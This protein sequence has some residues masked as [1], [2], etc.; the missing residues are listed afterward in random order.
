MGKLRVLSAKQVCQI[1][2]EQGFIQVRQRGSHIIMQKKIDDST[3]T[4]PV[5]NYSEI[6]IGTL[7][8]II[9]QSNLPRS[10]FE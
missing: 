4:I 6:K 7:Q 1:L 2:T 3:L 8:S 9:R 5:P 10:L